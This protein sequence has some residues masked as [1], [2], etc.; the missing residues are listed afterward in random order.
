MV[1]GGSRRSGG[2]APLAKDPARYK[3]PDP[4]AHQFFLQHPVCL[5][6]PWTARRYPGTALLQTACYVL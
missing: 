3:V 1:R 2:S 5:G 4:A 6:F